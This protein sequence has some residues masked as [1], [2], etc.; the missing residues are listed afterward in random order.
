MLTLTDEPDPRLESV[1][2]DGLAE[3]NAGQIGRRDWRALAV[4]AHDPVSGELVGGLLGRT[5]AR[6][7]WEEFGRIPS[8]PGVERIFMRKT[9][10]E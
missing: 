5:Y 9:F 1:L 4:A 8:V 2:E 3:Y 6:H 10:I 7:D